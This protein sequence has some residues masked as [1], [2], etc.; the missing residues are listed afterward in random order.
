[1]TF[2]LGVLIVLAGIIFWTKQQDNM[3]TDGQIQEIEN[4]ELEE[5]GITFPYQLLDGKVQVNSL[6]PSSIGNPDFNDEI[7]DDIA[8]LEIENISDEFIK[9]ANFTAYLADGQE[10]SFVVENI[11]AGK[12]VWAFEITNA[13]IPIDAVCEEIN[14]EA[15]FSADDV[16]MTDTI[17]VEVEMI[18]VKVSNLTDNEMKELSAEFHC[19]F[20]GVYF[21]GKS[22]TY[23]IDSIQPGDSITLQV[24]ECYLGEA[25]AVRITQNE[26]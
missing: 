24:E 7:G 21:G 15:E 19:L 8:S 10:L 4:E 14:C 20:D 1:M 3:N 13:S 17:A 23:P 25:E 5:E 26:E 16:M 12:S 11:P 9:T 6:F 22:Y 2:L 18:E